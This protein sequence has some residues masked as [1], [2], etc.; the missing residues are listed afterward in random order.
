MSLRLRRSDWWKVIN[1]FSN[2]KSSGSL[3]P[4][5]SLTTLFESQGIMVGSKWS[6]ADYKRR[7]SPSA[8]IQAVYDQWDRLSTDPP[9]CQRRSSQSANL[10]LAVGGQMYDA[11]NFRPFIIYFN[12]I[13]SE[14][15][16]YT[17]T[18]TPPGYGVHLNF[19]ISSL[20]DQI[21]V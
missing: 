3:C 19:R 20:I 4:H 7:V 8:T 6:L 2:G 13:I 15:R 9:R 17:A 1:S 18:R 12:P 21:G 14:Y 16:K 5:I 11:L 10:G